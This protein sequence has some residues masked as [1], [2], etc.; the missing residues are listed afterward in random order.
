MMPMISKR[1]LFRSL[2]GIVLV[3]IAAAAV[4]VSSDARAKNS[5]Q[6][7]AIGGKVKR[8]SGDHL[9]LKDGRYVEFAGIRLPYE[10]EPYAEASRRVLSKWLD[11]EG[12]RLQFD[13]QR[14]HRMDRILAYVYAN[15]TFIN[16]RLARDGLAFVKLRTGNRKFADSLLEA[17]S[18]AQTEAKGI[19]SIVTPTCNGEFIGDEA[20]ATFH[21]PTCEKL[22]KG[23]ALV[24][25]HGT[26]SAFSK[27]MAPC[28]N[29][30]PLDNGAT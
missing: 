2:A 30:R 9:K 21:R 27:G 19:W 22:P 20:G 15:D 10:N 12:V 23:A 26:I 13:E 24:E 29:C 1:I 5:S 18:A 7:L 8:L 11:D 3:G 16:E 25:L 17:Q 6:R 14:E 28:G 4:F